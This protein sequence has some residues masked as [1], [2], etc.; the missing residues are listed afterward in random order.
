VNG[1]S[2][3]VIQNETWPYEEDQKLSIC[4]RNITLLL[5]AYGIIYSSFQEGIG[6]R[7][8]RVSKALCLVL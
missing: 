7:Q 3:K 6:E 8:S 4:G 2:T 1:S 5:L